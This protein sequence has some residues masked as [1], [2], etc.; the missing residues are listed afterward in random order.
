MAFTAIHYPADKDQGQL[1]YWPENAE[2][3]VASDNFFDQFVTFDATDPM[4]LGSGSDGGPSGDLLADPP[5]PS[6]LL[7]SLEE[8]FNRSAAYAHVTQPGQPRESVVVG[9]STARGIPPTSSPPS[10][11]PEQRRSAPV[12]LA[13]PLGI[14]PIL[15]SGSISDSELLRLE[16]ISLKSP[17]TNAAVPSSPLLAGRVSSSPRKHHRVLDSIYATIRRATHR[18]KAHR[19]T[20][21]SIAATMTDVFKS[22]GQSSYDIP[23]GSDMNELSDIS[24]GEIK[25]ECERHGP[26]DSQGLPLSPPPTG[27]IPPTQQHSKNNDMM[28]FVS[29]HFEDPF[30]E[31]L[32]GPPAVINPAVAKGREAN[33]EMAT[34]D[35]PALSD[36]A[37]YQHLMDT[38]AS[39]QSY[40]RPHPQPK[41][42]STSSAEWPMEGIL[43][44]E[45][46]AN[47]IWPPSSPGP[48]TGYMPHEMTS[49]GWWDSPTHGKGARRQ[50]EHTSSRSH[51]NG[52]H[53]TGSLPQLSVHGQPAVDLPYEYTPTTPTPTST[54][55]SGLMIHMPQPRAPAAPVLSSSINESFAS[56]HGYPHPL[57]A[58]HPHPAAAGGHRYPSS[59]SSS[60]HHG[61][62]HHHP[63]HGER[64]PRP[65]APSSGARHHHHHGGAAAAGSLTSP[66]KA[67]SYYALREAS[68][69]P[70]PQPPPQAGGGLRHRASSSSLAVRKR[71]SWSRRH[72]SGAAEPRTPARISRTGSFDH[73]SGGGG[74]ILLDGNGSSLSVGGASGI[75]SSSRNG[76]GGGG[77]GGGGGFSIEFLNYTPDDKKVLM[78]GVAPS[79]SSKTKA[80]REREA[81]ENKRKMSEAAMHAIR[82]AGGDVEKLRQNGFFE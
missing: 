66:R 81:Q 35:T 53:A 56:S 37:F 65:R 78:N 7:D 27:R 34:I 58:P 10:A 80:R 68:V 39:A 62:A 26:I 33:D 6:L 45:N 40:S 54:D 5:S 3:G 42:R 79:G 12:E 8:S 57:H 38:T 21:G 13:D 1:S 9:T 29:G 82:A 4:M 31:G 15:S 28:N 36:D 71:R 30:D 25:Y 20:G 74:G 69:S 14:D 41:H 61:H 11:A 17:K 43:T 16:G 70:T 51:H 59:S 73:G 64:R 19:P 18:S 44:N 63:R 50:L 49:P 24:Q 77:G 47:S 55:L 52:L 2:L 60:S 32:L 23:S 48:A 22:K 67:S 75:G 72:A 76:L 46:T